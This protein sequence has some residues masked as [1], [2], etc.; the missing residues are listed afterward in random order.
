MQL[1][2]D[3]PVIP[4]YDFDNFIVCAG[5]STACHF[6]R[7]LTASGGADNLL[8]LYGPPGSGKTHL[9]MAIGAT[10]CRG[11]G[12]STIPCISCKDINEIYGGVY[13]YEEGSRLADQLR[14]APALLMDDIHKIPDHAGIRVE[15]WQLFND[16]FRTGRPIVI[17]GLF[18]PRELQ[19]LDEHLIS[20]LLWGLVAR[21]DISDDDSRRL[22]LKKLADDRQLFLPADV[23]NYLILHTRRDIPSLIETLEMIERFA[24]SSKRK[25]S[26]RLAREAL[27]R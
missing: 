1:V 13:R 17:T 10:V 25:L 20:R 27:A 22:I 5:N 21:M 24:L 6:A 12:L 26:V 15:F 14:E 4:R 23:I 18:P 19:N 3:F 2:F 9:L 8:Y 11:A 7:L 16:F